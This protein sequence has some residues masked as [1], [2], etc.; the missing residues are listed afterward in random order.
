[1]GFGTLRYTRSVRTQQI[2]TY[3]PL[4]W[5]ALSIWAALP[6][7][8]G[9]RLSL[10]L[11]PETAFR[12]V[13][14]KM[15]QP[16]SGNPP[17]TVIIFITNDCPIAN[18]YAPEINS[19]V[20]EYKPRGV[21]FWLAHVDGDL[22]LEDARKHA[23]DFGYRCPVIMDTH[24]MLSQAIGATVTPE[25]AVIDTQRRLVYRGRIDDRYIDFGK[26]RFAPTQRD[27]RAALDAVLEGLDVPCPRTRA[28]GCFI[29]DA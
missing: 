17:A 12:D 26:K 10:Q 2:H 27:L 25:A 24:H 1:M 22:S 29:P 20:A 11:A 18:A 6:G 9:Q 16:L 28:I 14:G 23:R 15:Q 7:C 4:V 13:N 5:I 19:M 21:A 8:G 3:R